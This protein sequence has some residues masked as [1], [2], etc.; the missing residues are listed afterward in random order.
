[1]WNRSSWAPRLRTLTLAVALAP[2]SLAAQDRTL[3]SSNEGFGGFGGPMFR[4]TQAAG[5]TM[6]LGG[7]GGA[8]IVGKRFAIGGAGFGGT[9]KVDARL[10]GSNV[11]G[12]MDFGYGGLTLEYIARSSDVIHPTF[13]VLVGGG[14]VSVWPDDLR[15]RLRDRGNESFGV[16]E[17]QLGLELNV[18][19]WMRI[20]GTVGYRAVIGSEESRL[21]DDKLSGASGTLVIRFGKF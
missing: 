10:N 11:R 15:P 21:V 20:G 17:P 9:T 5:E 14:A 16:V 4:I 8:F 7:G 18:L 2:L 12:E 3:I 19:H 6:A 1:M 13:G